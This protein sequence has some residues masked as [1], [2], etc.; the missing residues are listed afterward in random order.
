V[1]PNLCANAGYK[2][3]AAK[4]PLR[5]QEGGWLRV[6]GNEWPVVYYRLWHCY[7]QR[8]LLDTD[9]SLWR[10]ESDGQL[11]W[12]GWLT[13]CLEVACLVDASW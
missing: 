5:L 9:S 10:L 13:H 7:W 6:N 1:N 2:D 3:E 4:W 8:V 11:V 12:L